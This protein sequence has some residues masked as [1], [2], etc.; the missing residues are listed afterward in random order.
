MQ[1][2]DSF[3]GK[4]CFLRRF[5]D[6]YVGKNCATVCA[7]ME[8]RNVAL[9]GT[10]LCLMVVDTAGREHTKPITNSYYP[11]VHGVFVMFDVTERSS[12]DHVPLWTSEMHKH[13]RPGTPLVVVGLKAGEEAKEED[14]PMQ[15][16]G[17]ALGEASWAHRARPRQV[18]AAEARQL[19]E[20]LAEK[21][22]CAVP[23]IESSSKRGLRCGVEQAVYVLARQVMRSEAWLSDPPAFVQ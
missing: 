18:S 3:V 10:P 22:G 14:A 5:T 1:K 7:E 17:A 4:T 9:R 8:C 21:Y 20:R 16:R 23:Y 15:P 13:S 12:F 19:T 2:G 11:V 6:D